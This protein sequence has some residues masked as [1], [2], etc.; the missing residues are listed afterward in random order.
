MNDGSA[1]PVILPSRIWSLMIDPIVVCLLPVRNAE[2]TIDGWFASVELFADAVVALDDGS[3]DGTA[4]KLESNALVKVLL[5]NPTRPTYVGWNDAHNRQRLVDAVADLEKVAPWVESNRDGPVWIVQLDADERISPD[6]SVALKAFLRTEADSRFAYLLRCYRMIHDEFHFDRP[7]NWAGRVFAYRP[8]V[9]LPTD[10]L[11]FVP[12]PTDISPRDYRMTTIRIQHF[13]NATTELRKA[14]FEKYAEVDGEGR[15]Q[16]SY[17]HLLDEPQSVRPWPARMPDL[18]FE[19]HG[20]HPS[21]HPG[22]G[23]VDVLSLPGALS[24]AD[25]LLSTLRSL[26]GELVVFLEPPFVACQEIRVMLG[27]VGLQTPMAVV[28]GPRWTTRGHRF[29]RLVTRSM[30]LGRSAA[31]LDSSF[32]RPWVCNV[33]RRDLLLFL[34]DVQP[35]L[36]G[37]DDVTDAFWGLGYGMTTLPEVTLQLDDVRRGPPPGLVRQARARGRRRAR[38]VL[39]SHHEAGATGEVS[40]DRFGLRAGALSVLGLL[41]FVYFGP[42]VVERFRSTAARSAL[43][44]VLAVVTLIEFLSAR[45]VIRRNGSTPAHRVRRRF[46]DPRQ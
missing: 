25:D 18:P 1:F 9:R 32:G 13:G 44:P 10:A 38:H 27:A 26:S 41:R 24:F 33:F 45:A 22:S 46:P 8:G 3:T 12:L 2:M 39:E 37:L 42:S 15:Y 21:S 4:H 40:V 7:E 6:D 16:A 31:P 14:R 28:A 29:S 43:T 5:R 36:V 30:A 35:S 17:S 19:L 23:G 11:H 34:L 20:R